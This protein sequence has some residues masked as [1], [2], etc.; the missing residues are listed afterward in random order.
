MKFKKLIVYQKAFNLALDILKK[1]LTKILLIKQWRLEG[2][3]ISWS[4]ILKD[5]FKLNVINR[6]KQVHSGDCRLRTGDLEILPTCKG[7]YMSSFKALIVATGSLDAN[8]VLPATKTS[9]PAST[10]SLAF[11]TSTPPSTWISAWLPDSI[12]RV[13]SFLI[14]LKDWGMNLTKR[15]I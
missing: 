9:T 14:F 13:L 2:W 6:Y 5:L 11:E 8:T 3:L 10:N 15:L 1:I 4:I 12:I 7:G